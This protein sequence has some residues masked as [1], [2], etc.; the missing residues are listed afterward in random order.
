VDVHGR[1][2]CALWHTLYSGWKEKAEAECIAVVWPNGSRLEGVDG[3]CFHVP[4]LARTD[5][6]G[7]PGGNNVTTSSCCCLEEEDSEEVTLRP[8]DSL[9][10][11]PLFL[12][13]AIDRVLED[14]SLTE[15]Y[16]LDPNRVYMAGHSNGCVTSLAMAALYS[17]TIAAVCCHAGALATPFP[18]D[19]H[20]VPIWLVHGRKDETLP[21]EGTSTLFPSGE[22]GGWSMDQT[23]EY[24][25]QKND[26]NGD[27]VLQ[28]A[29]VD[30]NEDNVGTVYTRSDCGA[31]LELVELDESGHFPYKIPPML[32]GILTGFGEAPTTVDT[33]AMAWEFCE[34]YAKEDPPVVVNEEEEEKEE[35]EA[36][37]VVDEDDV[38]EEEE[39]APASSS[40]EEEEESS[41]AGN[42]SAACNLLLL[43]GSLLSA[44]MLFDVA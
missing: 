23:M 2:G 32:Q 33:T 41:S 35:A 31:H 14:A 44:F 1:G 13:M 3:T 34:A 17:D 25:R 40:L 18:E 24:L 20:P 36:E 15:D 6:Y 10:N 21:Y 28:E 16:N 11:D 30:D 26:C 12:K 19:Y 22:Y 4:G 7:L 29:L 43:V 5:D 42:V 27:F 37:P 9:P 8:D 39:E 38:E